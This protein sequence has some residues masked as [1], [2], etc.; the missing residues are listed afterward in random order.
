MGTP[1]PLKNSESKLNPFDIFC[2]LVLIVHFYLDFFLGIRLI[3]CDS[4]KSLL[5]LS[6]GYLKFV[7]RY[8][9]SMTFMLQS[10]AL[11]CVFCQLRNLFKN[12]H[13]FLV[14]NRRSWMFWWRPLL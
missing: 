8:I 3:N 5:Y 12:P 1:P 4:E 2:I 13:T 9:G 7:Y 14:Q 11:T 6:T 10:V